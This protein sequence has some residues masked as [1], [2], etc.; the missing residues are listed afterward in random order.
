MKINLMFGQKQE[1]VESGFQVRTLVRAGCSCTLDKKGFT[2]A[3]VNDS[4]TYTYKAFG[5]ED[6]QA[7]LKK[8]RCSQTL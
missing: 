6:A 5:K 2:Y 8:N 7:W 3:C 1:K 4:G